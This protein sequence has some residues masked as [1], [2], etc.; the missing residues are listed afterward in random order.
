VRTTWTKTLLLFLGTTTLVAGFGAVLWSADRE[1]GIHRCPMRKDTVYI[2][3]G[4]IRFSKEYLEA[5][6]GFTNANNEVLGGCIV[7]ESRNYQ[8]TFYCP[9]CRGEEK[10]WVARQTE[11][12]RAE[13]V[14]WAKEATSMNAT[15]ARG[16]VLIEEAVRCGDTNVMKEILA[17]SGTVNS[18]SSGYPV[19]LLVAII[20]GDAAAVR[21]LA[22]TGANLRAKSSDGLTPLHKAARSSSKEI[23]AA[24]VE[25]GADVMAKDQ[26]SRTPLESAKKYN[27]DPEVAKYLRQH[28]TAK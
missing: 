8:K 12:K 6:R 23:V 3:Y 16:Q 24:L 1:C 26:E 27:K 9:L 17:K 21:L 11:K 13:I 18:G 28:R 2:R 19:P 5:A 25:R 22:D 4:L 14:L 10:R 7:D 20:Y 15:N